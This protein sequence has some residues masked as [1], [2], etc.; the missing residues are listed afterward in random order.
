MLTILG[1]LKRRPHNAA[2]LSKR[3][4]HAD[5]ALWTNNS[6]FLTYLYEW[7]FC[8]VDTGL[9]CES[10]MTLGFAVLLVYRLLWQILFPKLFDLCITLFRTKVDNAVNLCGHTRNK[11]FRQQCR[12]TAK[13]RKTFKDRSF[14]CRLFFFINKYN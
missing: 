11:L 9:V 2:Q 8:T 14:N 7:A 4:P 6:E 5:V 10:F 13:G 1:T 3:P 12:I